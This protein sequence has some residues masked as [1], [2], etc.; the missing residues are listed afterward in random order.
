VR[1]VKA[2]VEQPVTVADNY[3][4]WRDFGASL[5]REVDFITMHSYP[6]WERK[7]IDEGLAFTIENY[8]QVRAA[9][10]GYPIV[11]GEA[12]W[13]TYTEGN[14]HVPRGGDER[15]QQRYYD[16]LTNWAADNSV[17]VFFFEAFDEA[18]KGTGTEGYWGLFTADRKAKP[19][20]QDAFPD[21]MPDGPTSPAYPDRIRTAGPEL[22]VPLRVRFAET[23]PDANVNPMGP[24]LAA[25]EALA[26]EGAEGGT[27]LRL[28]FNGEG[29]AGVFFYFGEYDA[30][31]AT[32]LAMR[33]RL[34]DEV[35]QLEL[36]LEGPETNT[37]SV[38]AID[39]ATDRDEAG[40]RTVHVPLAEFDRIDPSRLAI[41]GLWR[42][43]DR[44]GSFVA[45]EVLVDDVRFD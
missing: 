29:W 19:V 43:A 31:T 11:I 25:A 17:T 45:C 14:L 2:G 33:L 7:D 41:V 21:L 13:A 26:V 24:G 34:P 9:L 44:A 3:V 28:A 38:N 35:T 36:K 39:Y 23:I 22:K 4:W 32:A 5:A 42:P 15:K 40:W 1:E 12:G 10:P 18:W 16:E 20:V 27:A 37:Q 8:E 30:S 6:L